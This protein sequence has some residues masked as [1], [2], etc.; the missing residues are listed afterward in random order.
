MK[1][2]KSVIQYFYTVSDNQKKN[3]TS[4]KLRFLANRQ[5]PEASASALGKDSGGCG[6]KPRRPTT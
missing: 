5:Y 2:T 6:A 1:K 3:A 4:R